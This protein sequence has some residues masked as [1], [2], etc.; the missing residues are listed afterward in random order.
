MLFR[1]LLSSALGA[2]SPVVPNALPLHLSPLLCPPQPRVRRVPPRAAR[3]GRSPRRAAA[4]A[5][6]PRPFLPAPQSGATAGG[7]RAPWWTRWSRR[8]SRTRATCWWARVA[9]AGACLACLDGSFLHPSS[10]HIRTCPET[11][12]SRHTPT[13]THTCSCTCT[14]TCTCACACTCKF[15]CFLPPPPGV[16]AGRGGDPPGAAAAP[17]RGAARRARAAAAW[18]PR[19]RAAGRGNQVRPAA[20]RL[21]PQQCCCLC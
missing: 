7:W 12:T 15:T 1:L 14:C 3:Q 9:A 2:D 4:P 6:T 8:C 17:R 13:G 18:Q 10:T 21:P 19:A 5:Q 11:H 20:R 16:P